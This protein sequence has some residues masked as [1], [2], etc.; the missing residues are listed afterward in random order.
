MR[1]ADGWSVSRH[2]LA[3]LS[4]EVAVLVPT[5]MEELDEAD[6]ALGQAAGE[7]A[8]VGDKCR[9]CGTPAV[10]LETSRRVPRKDP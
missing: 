7:Q 10:E 1:A 8:V 4:G 6:A 2:W 5:A 9:A 3:K